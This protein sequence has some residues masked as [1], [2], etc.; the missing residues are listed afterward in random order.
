MGATTAAAT[1]TLTLTF[2]FPVPAPSAGRSPSLPAHA[3]GSVS[4]R[5]TSARF[6]SQNFTRFVRVT[7]GGLS[8]PT[9]PASY[10]SSI[11]NDA[12]AAAVSSS[13]S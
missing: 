13:S 8:L 4:A 2:V 1:L 11:S 3:P 6:L 5:L 10:S 9:S 7:V 12:M